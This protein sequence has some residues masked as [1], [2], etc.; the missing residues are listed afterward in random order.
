[1]PK[2]TEEQVRRVTKTIAR[3]VVGISV[4]YA[5]SAA[6]AG[7]LNPTKT[8]HKVQAYIGAM[9]VGAMVA[10]RAR[11]WIDNE[12]DEIFDIYARFKETQK[13]LETP[14]TETDI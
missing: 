7:N 12:V 13:P 6:L 4:S 8:R 1:M 3:N 5:V 14:D 9:A 10:D 2:Y 11:N